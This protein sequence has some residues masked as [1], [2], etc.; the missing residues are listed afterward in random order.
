VTWAIYR[1]R[2]TPVKRIPIDKIGLLSL[3][4]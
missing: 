1:D 2:E 4:A 3:I